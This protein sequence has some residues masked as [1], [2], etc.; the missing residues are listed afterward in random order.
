M[1]NVEKLEKAL[2]LLA[3][4]GELLKDS[5]IPEFTSTWNSYDELEEDLGMD[6]AR[7]QDGTL[8]E[9]D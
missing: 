5:K 1:I 6:I 9:D 7:V 8:T 3:E 4:V 2:E